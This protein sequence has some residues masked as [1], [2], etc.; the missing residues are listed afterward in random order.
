M[1]W[2]C[3]R[4]DPLVPSAAVSESRSDFHLD[5]PRYARETVVNAETT[6]AGGTNFFNKL[7]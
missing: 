3:Q 4:V 6:R 5:G 2:R 7:M 1:W